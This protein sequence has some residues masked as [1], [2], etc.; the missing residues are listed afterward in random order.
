MGYEISLIY[1][2]HVPNMN[3]DKIFLESGYDKTYFFK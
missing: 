1:Q 2:M 3:M